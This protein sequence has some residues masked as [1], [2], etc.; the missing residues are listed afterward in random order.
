MAINTYNIKKW[1][2]ML[3]GKSVLHVNQDIGKNFSRHEVLG[4]YNNMTEKVTMEPQ[5]VS[6]TELPHTPQAD[7]TIIIFPVAV[8]QYALG[9]YDL[10]LQTGEKSYLNKFMQHAEWTLS[11]QDEKGRWKNFEHTYPE[12]PYGAMA[13]GE[14]ASVLIRAYQETNDIKFLYAAKKGIDFMLL[15]YEEGGTTLY[16]NNDLILLE[17]THLPVVLNGW[18]FA[19][20]GLYDYVTATKD[21]AHYLNCLNQSCQSLIRYLPRFSTSYWSKYDLDYRI[22]SPFY[23]NLH[24]SQMEAMYILTGEKLFD[25]YSKRW[26]RQKANFFYKGFAFAKKCYQKICE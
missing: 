7:G 1:W 2:K 20:W 24:I 3:S 6:T 19:W 9:C 26:R 22:A 14:A 18:I 8:F 12:H 15:S 25:K 21:T 16:E 10:F 17:Y 4:Y 23:H 11:N 5:L 13:Q